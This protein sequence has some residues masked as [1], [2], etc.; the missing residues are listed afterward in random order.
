MNSTRVATDAVQPGLTS[1]QKTGS[2]KA[3]PSPE[4]NKQAQ[5]SL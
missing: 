5:H 1:S 2:E 3:C 4:F